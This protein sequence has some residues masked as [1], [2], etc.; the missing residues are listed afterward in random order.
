MMR[1]AVKECGKVY[2]V[3]AGPGDPRLLT[4]RGAELLR[5]AD[6]VVYDA[7]ASAA[8]LQL[9]PASAE[10]IDV[11]KRGHDTK[12][13][14]QEEID[15]LLVSLARAGKT[16][17]RL[18]GGDPFIFGRG[19]EEAS[20]LAAARIPFEIV[21]G[22]SAS[23]AAAAYAGIPLTDRRYAASFAVVTGHQDLDPKLPPARWAE[24]AHGV[25]TLVLLMGMKNLRKI[26]TSLLQ[27][28]RAA[29]T[30]AAA[31]MWGATPKQRVVVA[32]LADL[33]DAV[34][35]AGLSNPATVVIGEVVRLRET[36]AWY[37]ALPL[38]GLR[39]LVTRTPEQA[40]TMIDALYAAGAEPIAEPMI[41][42]VPPRNWDDLDRCLAQLAQYD[43]LVFTSQNAVHG[44]LER[45]RVQN[46]SLHN[47]RST[48]FCV[49]PK[50]TESAVQAGL[51][52]QR[53][54]PNRF[55]AEGVLELF[56]HENL[57][58]K[59]ILIPSAE[60]VR[61][62]LQDGLRQ[63]GAHVEV[64]TTYRT[65]A[66]DFDLPSVQALRTR[67]LRG[68][69]DV[70]TFTSPSTVQHFLALLDAPAR[71][72]VSN[73]VVAA[74]G[75]VTAHALEKAGIP[76]QI[77]AKEASAAALIE[78]L[79]AAPLVQERKRKIEEGS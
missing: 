15:S 29:Q 79:C 16:V 14:S 41:R 59:R 20:A 73:A 64:P 76:P 1:K 78:A 27:G 22:V 71:Q 60:K 51:H 2:L 54:P 63:A 47:L 42:I 23:H 43:F 55:D 34:E 44:F 6:V 7:L 11:G 45:A 18:K 19:G 40:S 26:V 74:I 38:Y 46:I 5:I 77:V 4:L 65:L 9:A 10:R 68:E 36:L 49:G 52:V 67:L 62:V 39:V 66:P 24:L 33:P 32:S 30:P 70:L 50:T 21:P 17:V 56:V 13:R 48:V 12:R 37:E 72:A 61:A 25:D 69:L 35:K 28:G 53:Q 3:G 58:G 57:R 75:P 8:L 31:I